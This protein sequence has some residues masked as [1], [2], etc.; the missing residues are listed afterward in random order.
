MI[1]PFQIG[2]LFLVQRLGRQAVRLN[3]IQSLIE[4]H[5]SFWTTLLSIVPWNQAKVSTHV[6]RRSGH[7][8]LGDGFL[9]VRRRN[10]RREVDVLGLAP[11]LASEEGHPAIWEKLLGHYNQIAAQQQ[12]ERI[13]ADV[14]D[15]PLPV[16]TFHRAGYRIYTRQTVWRLS[17]QRI[18]DYSGAIGAYIRPQRAED[19]WG[20]TRL[21]SQTVP[22]PIQMAEG[23]SGESTTPPNITWHNSGICTPYVLEESQEIRGLIQ[24]VEGRRGVWFQVWLD[25]NDPNPHRI[26]ELLRYGL[27]ILHRRVVRK[28]IYVGVPEYQ[29]GM[30]AILTDYGFAPVSDQ[31]RMVRH[32]AHWVRDLQTATRRVLESTPQIAI[33]PFRAPYPVGA[34]LPDPVGAG[35][36]EEGTICNIFTRPPA[37]QDHGLRI[38]F[39]GTDFRDVKFQ[40]MDSQSDFR[41]DFRTDSCTESSN[42]PCSPQSPHRIGEQVVA[43]QIAP[44]TRRAP[45]KHE[46]AMR[47]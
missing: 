26:H 31:A 35:I 37:T 47:I 2:D 24:I 21:Y 11:A 29:A 28:P 22:K 18:D 17:P 36:G 39:R 5:S 32:V 25:T 4:P 30:N 23:A 3:T 38:D 8:L 16:A 10:A 43:P 13:Y 42:A 40:S 45:A 34:G 9:L 1:R 19:R 44:K 41:S 15:L 46:Q 27:S 14:A 7:G 6:L 12:I 33:M 20:L